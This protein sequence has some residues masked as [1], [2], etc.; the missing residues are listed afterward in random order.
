MNLLKNIGQSCIESS[1][2][3]L[4]TESISEIIQKN[5]KKAE[6]PINWG[7]ANFAAGFGLYFGS[8]AHAF[9]PGLPIPDFISNFQ[10]FLLPAAFFSWALT[11]RGLLSMTRNRRRSQQVGRNSLGAANCK[12]VIVNEI[13]ESLD[14]TPKLNRTDSRLGVKAILIVIVVLLLFV[15]IY[16]IRQRIP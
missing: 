8:I 6:K 13:I 1:R 7:P 10:S 5:T 11:S 2:A 3:E 16:C 12:T 9:F 14:Q 15:F 4:N